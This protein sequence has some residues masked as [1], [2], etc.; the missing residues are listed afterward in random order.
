VQ[1]HFADR[2]WGLD[3]LILGAVLAG[4]LHQPHAILARDVAGMGVGDFANRERGSRGRIVAPFP[5]DR[6]LC[7]LRRHEVTPQ[8]A[9]PCGGNPGTKRFSEKNPGGSLLIGRVK[10]PNQFFSAEFFLIFRIFCVLFTT[11]TTGCKRFIYADR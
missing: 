5:R 9:Q 3:P 1:R 2:R 6:H 7:H 11:E 10:L 8:R 4:N